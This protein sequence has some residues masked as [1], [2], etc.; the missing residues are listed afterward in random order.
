MN[1]Q[2]FIKQK[3]VCAYD[4]VKVNEYHFRAKQLQQYLKAV[5]DD[6][7]SLTFDALDA[8]LVL[9]YTN[10]RSIFFNQNNNFNLDRTLTVHHKIPQFGGTF[11]N[12]KSEKK[13]KNIWEVELE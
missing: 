3:G 8:A 5:K 12:T 6:I 11:N 1:L 13:V 4:L 9:K 7:I 10:G 2:Q